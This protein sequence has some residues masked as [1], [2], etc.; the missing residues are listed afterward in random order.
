MKVYV[1]KYKSYLDYEEQGI[2]SVFETYDRAIKHIIEELDAE[3]LY[4]D[5]YENNNWEYIVTEE[6]VKEWEKLNLELGITREK[7]W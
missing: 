6:E 7:L 2:E 4:D 1:I 3:H 5:R